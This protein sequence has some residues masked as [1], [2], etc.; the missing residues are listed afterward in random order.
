MRM[1]V[2]CLACSLS[3]LMLTASHFTEL[4]FSGRAKQQNAFILAKLLRVYLS[5]FYSLSLSLSLSLS[6][7][8]SLS[9]SLFLSLF[10]SLPLSLYLSF[11]LFLTYSLSPLSLSF[12]LDLLLPLTKISIYL[13]LINILHMQKYCKPFFVL[14]SPS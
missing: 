12:S 7:S 1:I 10:L 8:L 5:K 9:L 3:K 14:Y 11:Y 2:I 4:S 13:I 6:I